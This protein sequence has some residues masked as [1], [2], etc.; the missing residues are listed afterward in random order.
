MRKA[1]SEYTDAELQ[2]ELHRRAAL[3]QNL[4]SG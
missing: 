2:N 3:A 1:I 4:N